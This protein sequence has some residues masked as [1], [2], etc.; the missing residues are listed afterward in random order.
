[1]CAEKFTI[2]QLMKSESIASF[3]ISKNSKKLLYSS[4]SSGSFDIYELDLESFKSKRK[5]ALNE[6]ALVSY[7]FEDGSFLFTMDKGGDELHHL[8]LQRDEK[9]VDLTPWEGTKSGFHRHTESGIYYYSNRLDK[10]RFDLYR[11]SEKTLESELVFDNGS[12]FEL[13]PVSSDG[14]L[15]ALSKPETANDSQMYVYDL[16]TG[17]LKHVSKHEGE[18]Q[19]N[20]AF[21]SKNAEELFYMSDENSEFLRLKAV[22]L[23][24]LKSREVISFD[25]DILSAE[26]SRD[27][28]YALVIV[29]RDAS[30][31]L[32]TVDLET[33]TLLSSE[34]DPGGVIYQ[35]TFD[36]DSKNI[37][38]LADTAVSSPDIFRLNIESGKSEKLTNTMA[39]EV[40]SNALATASVL[41][42]NSYDGKEVPG[43]FYPPPGASA[44]N[45]VPALIWVH[46][47]PGG[48][49]FPRYNPELQYLVNHGYAVYA[50]NNRGSSGYGKSFFKAADHRHGEADLDDCV[51]AADYLSTL[52]SI[53]GDRIGIIGGS[54]GGYMVL[55]ALAFRPLVF[56]V[57]IDIFGVSNWIRTLS[58]VPPWWRMIKDLLYRKIGDPFS[59]VEYLKSISPLFHADKI[60]RPLLVL[61]GANDPRVLKVESDE[62]VHKVREKGI[63]TGYIIFPDEGHG[64]KRKENR[65]QAAKAMLEFLQKHMA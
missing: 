50:V 3:A 64:F 49:S 65:V 1:M 36:N 25:W 7:V 2:E 22:D 46:G 39:G 33:E 56:K 14:K 53:D 29:N 37:F 32:H 57:G 58:E 12:A 59:E 43:I 40:D 18:I 62:I 35:Q 41:R 17:E 54:Y 42:F 20:P 13:G 10:T 38:F 15:L 26:R 11:L 27:G 60:E 31:T 23:N 9:L 30:F 63:E 4:D 5:T 61:Q 8:Y 44:E 28:R 55:A 51:K 34:A 16:N 6:N 19:Y 48:Q 24:S 45:K 21:F 52:E 47:G